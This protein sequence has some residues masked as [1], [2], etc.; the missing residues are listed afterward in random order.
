MFPLKVSCWVIFVCAWMCKILT[1]RRDK[2][3]AIESKNVSIV[4]LNLAA[5]PLTPMRLCQKE[6]L[7]SSLTMTGVKGPHSICFCIKQL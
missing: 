4:L 2:I 1:T 3:R 6:P 7:I 5:L